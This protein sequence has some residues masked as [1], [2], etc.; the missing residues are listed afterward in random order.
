M[1][2]ITQTYLNNL[3]IQHFN[4]QGWELLYFD[5]PG[6]RRS[7]VGKIA[8]I[9]KI[10]E[11]T[12]NLSPDILLIKNSEILILEVDNNFSNYYIE[13]FLKYKSKQIELICQ[14]EIVLSIKIK[15]LRFGFISK[16]QK[17]PKNI[18][19]TLVPFY[20]LYY[21]K[22]MLKEIIISS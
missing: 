9:N 14:L 17:I 21:Y 13:K 4:Q 12:Y 20:F 7:G 19:P 10:W 3:A 1:I 22:E 8:K 5:L 18:H 11:R 16:S 2:R 15:S 6:G